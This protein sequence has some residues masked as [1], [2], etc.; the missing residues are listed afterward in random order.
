MVLF[1]SEK[2]LR[3]GPIPQKLQKT[4]TKTNK[5]IPNPFFTEETPQ[6]WVSICENLRKKMYKQPVF[7]REKNPSKWV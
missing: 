6:K 3:R 4:K 5:K 1:W 7:D 2:I